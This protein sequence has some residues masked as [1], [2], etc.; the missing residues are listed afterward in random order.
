MKIHYE[1]DEGWV[2]AIDILIG[3]LPAREVER[4]FGKIVA[5]VTSSGG[6]DR[7]A[8]RLGNGARELPIFNHFHVDACF[9][10]DAHLGEWRKGHGDLV[11]LRCESCD[12][13]CFTLPMETLDD[14][15][16]INAVIT[17]APLSGA[18]RNGF[19]SRAGRRRLGA[20]C[21]G[22]AD[23]SRRESA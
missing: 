3:D 9:N 13:V 15:A 18:L 16:R 10:R 8:E 4:A 7:I 23:S 14:I 12:E 2:H 6:P 20:L 1:I 19:Y 11:A 21:E 17:S 5:T 22:C